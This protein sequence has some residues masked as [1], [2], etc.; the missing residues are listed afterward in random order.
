MLR[1]FFTF[2]KTKLNMNR[3][4]R[5]KLER[6]IIYFS[7]LTFFVSGICG[8]FLSIKN[9]EFYGLLTSI[10]L[11]A[12]SVIFYNISVAQKIKIGKD[13]Q[14]VFD[15]D[16]LSKQPRRIRRKVLRN[17]KKWHSTNKAN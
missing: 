4:E 15:E 10:F 1:L 9:F 13:L 3:I 7:Q 6:K 17:T 14:N 16:V 11:I 12:M 5:F 8:I 2:A